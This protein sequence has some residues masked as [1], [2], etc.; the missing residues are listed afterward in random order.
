[1]RYTLLALLFLTS[2]SRTQL[3]VFTDTVSYENLASFVVGTPDPLLDC[4]DKGE[5]LVI[6]WSLPCL[7]DDSRVYAR[8]RFRNLKE[9]EISIPLEKDR[10]FITYNVINQDYKDSGGIL[11]YRVFLMQGENIL[12]ESQ[13]A[14]WT[15]LILFEK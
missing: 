9:V 10:G 11:T 1:M 8:V 5:R 15:E 2:C 4:P 7:C 13:H 12:E 14:L 3:I 6:S